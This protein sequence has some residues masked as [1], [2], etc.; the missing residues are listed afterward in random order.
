MN[1][2]KLY[3]AFIVVLTFSNIFCVF[4]LLD[5]RNKLT[6]DIAQLKNKISD[7]A[8][9]VDG[10]RAH[11]LTLINEQIQYYGKTLNGDIDLVTVGNKHLNF[12]DIL[13]PDGTIIYR[14]TDKSCEMCYDNVLANLKEAAEIIGDDKIIVIVPLDHLRK[15]FVTFNENQIP[16]N[17]LAIKNNEILGLES[18]ENGFSPFFFVATKDLKVSHIFIPSTKSPTVTSA[19]L[20][21]VI[22][23]MKN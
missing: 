22:K 1:Q 14:W 17:I 9:E 21:Q 18:L 20:N 2:S 11:L 5:Y 19:Y 7:Q 15:T 10:A 4:K 12:R 13:T 6:S 16:I 3:I 8:I 23:N